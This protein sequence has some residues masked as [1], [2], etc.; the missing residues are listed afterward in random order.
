[1]VAELV[2]G[3]GHGNGFGSVW[4]FL[5]GEDRHT[6]GAD[7]PFRIKPEVPGQRIVEANE[8]RGRHHSRPDAREKALRQPGIAVVERD[9]N[10]HRTV[11]SGI[12]DAVPARGLIRKLSFGCF[13]RV[14]PILAGI[15]MTAIGIIGRRAAVL[16]D[17]PAMKSG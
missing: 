10:G 14:A 16:S 17:T 13:Y 15:A 1:E 12:V 11:K 3:I 5:A 4:D 8:L 7:K 6:F 2:S 9:V